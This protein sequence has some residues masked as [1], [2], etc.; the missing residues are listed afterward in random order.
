MNENKNRLGASLYTELIDETKEISEDIRW[1]R[2]E[3]GKL[4]LKIE[5]WIE[6][7]RKV[8]DEKWPNE[9]IYIGRSID[10]PIS[11]IIGGLVSSMKEDELVNFFN[12]QKPPISVS[13]KF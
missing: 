9:F 3:E 7:Q 2:S 5:S 10:E 4:I 13:Y 1:S 12:S 11:L 8:L 6:E